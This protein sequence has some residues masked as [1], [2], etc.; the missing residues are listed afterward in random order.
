MSTRETSRC[1]S[2]DAQC[3]GVAP[4]RSRESTSAPR[5][6]SKRTTSAFP[7]IAATCKGVW[8]LTSRLLIFAPRSNNDF[9]KSMF[10]HLRQRAMKPL[11]SPLSFSSALYWAVSNVVERI[12]LRR[13]T[14]ALYSEMKFATS[15]LPFSDA[16]SA[17]VLFALLSMLSTSTSAPCRSNSFTTSRCPHCDAMCNGVQPSLSAVCIFAPW[18]IRRRAIATCP[19]ATAG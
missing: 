10:P 6:I 2:I 17:A 16:N 5:S 13:F 4:H 14:S 9:T 11:H 18:S 1:P 12:L 19:F 3:S 8:L 15:V 7:F